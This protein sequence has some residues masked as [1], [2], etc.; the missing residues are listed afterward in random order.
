MPH[1][2]LPAVLAALT[3]I[4]LVFWRLGLRAFTKRAVG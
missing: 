1:M 4:T 3:V 2:P